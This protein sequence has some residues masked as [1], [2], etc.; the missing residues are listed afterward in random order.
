[1]WQVR[2]VSWFPDTFARRW[3]ERAREPRLP[4]VIRQ[5]VAN[6]PWHTEHRD[7]VASVLALSA[8]LLHCRGHLP[9]SRWHVRYR[10]CDGE[11]VVVVPTA[12]TTDAAIATPAA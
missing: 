8:W 9:L 4:D 10:F 1:M 11:H 12:G 6:E 2:Q 7:D 3:S 5:P